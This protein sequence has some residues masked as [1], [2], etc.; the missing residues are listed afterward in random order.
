MNKYWVYIIASQKNGTLYIGV[1]NNIIRR[2]YEHKSGLIEGFSKKYHLSMLVYFE[3][4]D[5]IHMALKREKSLK[6]W[7]REWKIQLIERYNP[8]WVG[9]YTAHFYKP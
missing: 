2:T 1:T 3:E 6:K 5:D 8:G 7:R 9:L 4:Y